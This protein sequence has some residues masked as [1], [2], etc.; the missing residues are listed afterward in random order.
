MAIAVDL[1]RKATKQTNKDKQ[2][3]FKKLLKAWFLKA[4]NLY[5]SY[6]GTHMGSANRAPHGFHMYIHNDIIK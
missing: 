6:M 4:S 2:K 5:I 3:L 1:R